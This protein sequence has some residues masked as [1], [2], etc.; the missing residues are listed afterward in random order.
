MAKESVKARQRKREAM[1]AK[2]AE[3]R[4]ALKAAGDYAA[5]DQLPK[6]ASPVRLHNRCQLSG[7]PKGYMRH[8]GLCRNMFRDLALAGKIPGVRKASW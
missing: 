2:F 4:A 7:R 6:N 5:L 1:V 8:F 3:K